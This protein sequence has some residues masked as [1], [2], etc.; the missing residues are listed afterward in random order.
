MIDKG[1]GIMKASALANLQEGRLKNMKLFGIR[2]R[3]GRG[4]KL[5]VANP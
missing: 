4:G 2:T 5:V 1:L 3:K